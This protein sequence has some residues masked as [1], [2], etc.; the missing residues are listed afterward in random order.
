MIEMVDVIGLALAV[1][2]GLWWAFL[3]L[4]GIACAVGIGSDLWRARPWY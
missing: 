4:F 1:A 2:H 3:V